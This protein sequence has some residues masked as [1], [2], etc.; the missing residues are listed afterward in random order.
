MKICKKC[1]HCEKY[2]KGGAPD[3]CVKGTPFTINPVNGNKKYEEKSFSSCSEKNKDGKCKDY[4]Y[5][6][7][8]WY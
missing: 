5:K 7:F 2:W 1:K 6:F 3:Q 4:S 8:W